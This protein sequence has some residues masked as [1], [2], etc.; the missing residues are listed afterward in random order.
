MPHFFTCDVEEHF[1]VSAFDGVVARRDWERY[2]SRVDANTGILLD[3]LARHGAIGTFFVVGWVAQ[4][5]PSLVRRIAAAGHEIASHS[6]WHR[7]VPTLSRDEFLE[8]VTRT[9]VVLEDLIGRPVVG[10]RAPSFSILP[11]MDWA[12]DVLLEAG[13]AWDSSIFP[14]RRRGYG[15]PGAPLEPFSIRR[16]GGT[17]E[18]YPMAVLELGPI[19][20]PAAGGGYL[21]QLP[22]AVVRQ[23]FAARARAGRPGM[24][25]I[26]PWE[27]DP[28]QPRI[29]CGWMTALRHYRGLGRTLPR[30]E[31]LLTEFAF[32]AVH[33]PGAA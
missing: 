26:H 16:P 30:L 18:E 27:V 29:P 1:Q 33:T 17:I 7:R 19:R 20:I 22:F 3:L 13:Y 25:Y 24:F 15:W 21:R 6:W 23:A 14:I 4:R 5:N 2:P 9:R 31:R 28:G 12:F 11:G 32:T 10:F 8:D